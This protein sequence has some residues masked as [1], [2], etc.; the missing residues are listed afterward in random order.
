M[1][2]IK[3]NIYG[4]GKW[5]DQQFDIATDYQVIF[6]NNEAGK[7][8]FLNFIKSILFG[9]ASGRGNNKFAQY[10]P[11]KG[12]SYGGELEFIDGQTKWLVRR[13]DGKG[14]GDLS[15]FRDGQQVP[16][17]LLTQITK[18]FS[19]A[20]FESTHVFNDETMRSVYQMDE[21]SLE[22]EILSLGALCSKQWLSVAD[23][24]EKASGDVYKSRG[25]KQPLILSI[26]KYQK[27][28][29]ERASFENQ[30]AK[31][32]KFQD[33]IIQNRQK[34]NQLE[35]D[36][37]QNQVSLNRTK[38]LAEKVATYQNYQATLRDI[39]QSATK[40]SETEYNDFVNHEQQI[41]FIK[42]VNAQQ[43]ENSISVEEDAFMKNYRA[44]QAD[45]DYIYSRR[46]FVQNTIFQI[47][48][49]QEQLRKSDFETDQLQQ[50]NSKLTEEMTKLSVDEIDRLQAP[51][52]KLN[53]NMP[54]AVVLVSLI[55]A[56]VLSGPIRWVLIAMAILG[57]LYGGYQYQQY[58]TRQASEVDTDKTISSQHHFSNVTVEEALSLQTA[59]D[60]LAE[61][62]SQQ[63]DL[64][65][66]LDQS[67]GELQK[68]R[69][70]YQKVGIISNYDQPDDFVAKV[71]EYF[72][73]LNQIKGKLKALDQ[74]KS[75]ADSQS[76]KGDLAKLQKT[77]K[78][79][80]AKYQMDSESFETAYRKQKANQERLDKVAA[81]KK[82]LGA[83]WDVFTQVDDLTSF[84]TN[85]KNSQQKASQLDS[86]YNDLLT[87]KGYLESS[88]KQV[89]DDRAYQQVVDDLTDT[90]ETMVEQY[91]EWLTNKLASDWIHQMLMSASERRFPKMIERAKKY[92]E[93]LTD[94]NYSGI[95]MTS[96]HNLCL[97]SADKMTYDVHELSKATTVQLY[98]SLRM[99]F[100]IEISDIVDLPILIDD[101]FVDFDQDRLQKV[102]SMIE[103]VAAEHQIIF[104]TANLN[105][106]IPNDHVLKLEGE[107][108]E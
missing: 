34:I 107:K 11:K 1:K 17:K 81:D 93:T 25:M 38:I 84:E 102:F 80:L 105:K 60:Q 7:T 79:I 88:L 75:Q 78:E 26:K 70:L 103:Q 87:E 68:W 90:K 95:E 49:L 96:E 5:I 14:D 18:G 92:F 59:I 19:K 57:A 36:R 55:I 40:I 29:Q 27:L 47:E 4:F 64:Q 62:R 54:V 72:N 61:K 45:I 66:K 89:F 28:L 106:N 22:T 15:L 86:Q 104:V 94:G 24:L 2:L 73:K 52:A 100:V 23:D 58:R 101:A 8:T 21:Q 82:Y 3:V 77:Q 53:L 9:F 37:T 91:D 39:D 76:G 48:Q 63:N 20:D 85:F 69:N 51:K 46:N 108:D 30:Q 50:N 56:L 83:D 99:A 41:E 74:H 42:Q 35:N 71:D 16:N 43:E 44:N 13:V 32:R 98:I 65:A 31:Y 33:K 6:G 12:T 67:E 97:V 10:R